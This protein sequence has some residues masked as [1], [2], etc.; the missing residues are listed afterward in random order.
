MSYTCGCTAIH[1]PKRIVLTGG[2]GAGKTAV[3]EMLAH[4]VCPHVVITKEAAGILFSGGFP[5]GGDAIRRAA[6]QRAIYHV[7]CELENIAADGNPVLIL[8]DR[9]VVDGAAYWPGPGDF[10]N[11]V[12]TTR[13]EAHARYDAVVH[14]RVPDGSNGYGYQNPLRVESAAQAREIDER[15][16][17]AW[18]GHPHRYIVEASQDFL[19]KARRALGIIHDEIHWC[20]APRRVRSYDVTTSTG[21]AAPATTDPT[22]LPRTAG[23]TLPIP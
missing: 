7:Q 19:A 11:A 2:P 9:G 15:I 16:F 1:H 20:C 17:A 6:A 10:W 8:F 23:I 5:R 22:T 3:L 12:G 4:E 13:A 21:R 14:L 18:S